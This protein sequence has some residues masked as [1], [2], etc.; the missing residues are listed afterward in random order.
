[1]SHAIGTVS[2]H[3][4]VSFAVTLDPESR[5]SLRDTER[6]GAPCSLYGVAVK[7]TP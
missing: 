6:N 2:Q 7:V 1:M 4:A 3:A 5:L